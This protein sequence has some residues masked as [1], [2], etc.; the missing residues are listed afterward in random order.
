MKYYNPVHRGALSYRENS[1]V[2]RR[3]PSRASSSSSLAKGAVCVCRTTYFHELMMPEDGKEIRYG[4]TAC[5]AV[6]S[7]NPRLAADGDSSALPAW[8][9]ALVLPGCR[10]FSGWTA[11]EESE[12]RP[13]LWGTM[14]ATGQ[15]LL[16]LCCC[17]P[18]TLLLAVTQHS[19]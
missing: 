12:W 5:T 16:Y 2:F 6:P 9:E 13:A 7:A 15:A 11:N 14:R 19:L 3:G 18:G 8:P 17:A 1:Q 4:L 10:G